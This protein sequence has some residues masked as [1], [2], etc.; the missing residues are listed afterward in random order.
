MSS[1]SGDRAQKLAELRKL[2]PDADSEFI[3][4]AFSQCNHDVSTAANVLTGFGYKPVC[5]QPQPPSAAPPPVE[6]PSPVARPPRSSVFDDFKPSCVDRALAQA[7]GD[8][9][10][11]VEV[12]FVS[13]LY[14]SK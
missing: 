11:A 5:V 7:K 6:D 12:R 8:E 4:D 3:S 14:R 2:F 10:A 13:T 9:N 1:T